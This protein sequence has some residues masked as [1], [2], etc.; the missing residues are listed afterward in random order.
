MPQLQLRLEMQD[1]MEETMVSTQ[2]AVSAAVEPAVAEPTKASAGKDA[3]SGGGSGDSDSDSEPDSG[4][5]DDDSSSRSSSSN[6]GSLVAGGSGRAHSGGGDNDGGSR[7]SGSNV[8]EGSSK[9]ESG[10]TANVG[11]SDSDAAHDSSGSSTAQTSASDTESDGGG[12]PAAID[13]SGQHAKAKIVGS[14][15]AEQLESSTK[16]AS[17][18]KAA[19]A[20]GGSVAASDSSS[21][22][23]ATR[24]DAAGSSPDEAQLTN[25]SSDA[26]SSKDS[27]AAAATAAEADQHSGVPADAPAGASVDWAACLKE[28][29]AERAFTVDDFVQA[30]P[31]RVK[32]EA[33]YSS[34][35]P[36]AP[37]AVTM[38]AVA[39]T[40]RQDYLDA[41]CSS[42]GSVIT[43]AYYVA[44]PA[45]D[46]EPA[47]IVAAE[48]G[49][50]K[51]KFDQLE[52]EAK[53]QI[54]V[55]V[56]SERV[57][58]AAKTL[59][60]INVLRNLAMLMAQTELI[61]LG[62]LDMLIGTDLRDVVH[63]AEKYQAL[64]DMTAN[65]RIVVV[66][67]FQ[68]WVLEYAVEAAEGGKEVAVQKWDGHHFR[69]FL[70]GGFE[71]AHKD[72]DFPRWATATEAYELSNTHE[73][74]EPWWIARRAD[75]APY[76]VRYRGYGKNK[77]QHLHELVND[78]GFRYVV[79]PRAYMAHRPHE[80]S[81][82]KHQFDADIAEMEAA[83]AAGKAAPPLSA[84]AEKHFSLFGTA[85]RWLEEQIATPPPH[86]V[87]VC[88]GWRRC[89]DSLP[90][91]DVYG[92][93]GEPM[94]TI[95]SLDASEAGQSSSGSSDHAGT[96]SE[97]TETQPSPTRRL[98]RSGLAASSA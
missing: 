57:E 96:D 20:T 21:Q 26:A 79:H 92:A 76:D 36:H 65:R 66:P 43:L 35:H 22:A 64:L 63:D 77:L 97:N 27:P 8:A 74:F 81:A 50:I 73:L 51:Q 56:V 47:A 49:A 16:Q 37:T 11:S 30:R 13:S 72:T 38:F 41:L 90:F 84:A 24:S 7:N 32:V 5:S 34:R 91:W 71:P 53:C 69:Y 78:L 82:A 4:G 3:G 44:V 83:K 45:D 52:A 55:L 23:Q 42:W 48:L 67:T 70:E 87:L 54:D 89:R 88:A 80:E 29:D 40:S 2:P 95:T 15:T 25:R 17:R 86:R 14:T 46:P 18:A 93:A 9:P 39:T 75:I 85:Q 98:L 59:F 60:P 10:G 12:D 61:M 62:D 6:K 31:A 19:G 68:T 28:G 58:G 94:Q 33:A 1:E